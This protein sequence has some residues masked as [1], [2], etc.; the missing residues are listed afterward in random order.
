M[1]CVL[2]ALGQT[3]DPQAF[4]AGSP[5]RP[6][7]RY[8]RGDPLSPSGAD[9]RVASRSGFNLTVS[10]AGFDDL[11]GQIRD[12][13]GF[14]DEHEDELRRLGSFD[15]VELVCLHF[16]VRWQGTAVQTETFPPELLWRAGALDI[17]LAISHYVV[18]EPS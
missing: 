4:L 1:T 10:D 12:A 5:F 7:S 9:G 16:G 3:F 2:R 11:P 17:E 18:A 15:G 8:R 14:L 13:I 6:E